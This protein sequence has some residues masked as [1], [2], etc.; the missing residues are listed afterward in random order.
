MR[1]SD[2]FLEGMPG[3]DDY[4]REDGIGDGTFSEVSDMC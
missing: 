3:L 4:E 2:L 1:G